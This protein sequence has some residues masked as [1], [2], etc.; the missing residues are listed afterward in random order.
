MQPKWGVNELLAFF[1]N[2]ELSLSTFTLDQYGILFSRM[3][4]KSSKAKSRT[5]ISVFATLGE[6]RDASLKRQADLGIARGFK[7]KSKNEYRECLCNPHGKDF[8][9]WK[10]EVYA[11]VKLAITGSNTR[12][13]KF[14]PLKERRAE[15]KKALL[16][17]KWKDLRAEL[18]QKHGI[19]V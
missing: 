19:K 14:K 13:F 12:K 10:L 11:R 1:K 6:C 8:H 5:G 3:A 4:F 18:E 17:L 7:S 16:A 9:V 15:I 2:D